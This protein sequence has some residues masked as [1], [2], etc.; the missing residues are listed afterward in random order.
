MLENLTM[1]QALFLLYMEKRPVPAIRELMQK[2]ELSKADVETELNSLVSKDHMLLLVSS[3]TDYYSES[4]TV[5]LN[6]E[7]KPTKSFIKFNAARTKEESQE[8]N[9]NDERLM[10]EKKPTFQSKI[11]REMKLHKKRSH[12]EL[13]DMLHRETGIELAV[14][15]FLTSRTE[16]S[17]S[18]FRIS[19][20]QIT[21]L[22]IPAT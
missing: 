5:K 11:M 20:N 1:W 14:S 21:F 19:S 2:F 4:D 7:F 18:W 8:V 9:Q 6:P 15:N 13:A 3:S 10:N 17:E 12:T 16:I 22:E